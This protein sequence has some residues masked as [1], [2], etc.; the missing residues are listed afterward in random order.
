MECSWEQRLERSEGRGF[1]WRNKVNCEVV[2]LELSAEHIGTL[3][4]GRSLKAVLCALVIGSKLP[5]ENMTLDE[6]TAFLE[7]RNL[8][9]ALGESLQQLT[10]LAAGRMS[11]CF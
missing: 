1:E 11:F 9:K 8:D 10:L 5:P 4:A 7:G 6:A 2:L 3:Q